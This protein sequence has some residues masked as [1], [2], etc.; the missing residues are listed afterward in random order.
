MKSTGFK[1]NNLD[2]FPVSEDRMFIG[3][4]SSS[5]AVG[6][7]FAR[8]SEYLSVVKEFKE[9]VKFHG[10]LNK[11]NNS[12]SILVLR[13]NTYIE[14]VER[15]NSVFLSVSFKGDKAGFSGFTDSKGIGYEKFLES[16]KRQP[17]ILVALICEETSEETFFLGVKNVRITTLKVQ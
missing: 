2:N 8:R 11:S 3:Q 6:K 15:K 5:P 16:Y 10:L 12:N 17:S 9:A 1:D 7:M 14:I 4:I 13:S